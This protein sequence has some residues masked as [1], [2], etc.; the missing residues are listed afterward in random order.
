MSLWGQEVPRLVGGQNV[1]W[2]LGYE[3]AGS[4]NSQVSECWT[5]GSRL[6]HSMFDHSALLLLTLIVTVSEH[7]MERAVGLSL[8]GWRLHAFSSRLGCRLPLDDVVSASCLSQIA[9]LSDIG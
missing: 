9:N 4:P 6:G 1:W 8:S 5:A 3:P 2:G 7:L